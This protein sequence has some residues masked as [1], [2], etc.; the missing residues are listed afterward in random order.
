MNRGR[1][2]VKWKNER[3][4][5]KNSVRVGE[6][7]CPDGKKGART[8]KAK[9]YVKSNNESR[10]LSRLFT[11]ILLSW[12]PKLSKCELTQDTGEK[13]NLSFVIWDCVTW[14]WCTFM[15]WEHHRWT[16]DEK[17]SDFFDLI[18]WKVQLLTLSSLEWFFSVVKFYTLRITR[19][20]ISLFLF[21][22]GTTEKI[23]HWWFA[24]N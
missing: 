9:V 23:S 4:Q 3:W 1:K 2:K 19:N 8:R 18:K 7:P 5:I 11:M 15:T 24:K 10:N 6:K 17:W 16:K 21:F 13:K 12:I 14:K 20:M 22:L